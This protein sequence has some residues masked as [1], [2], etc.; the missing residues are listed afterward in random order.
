MADVRR[1]GTT[2]AA[3][4][5]ILALTAL[6]TLFGVDLARRA[7]DPSLVDRETYLS[8]IGLG[9]TPQEAQNLT[10]LTA[11]ILLGLCVL[12]TAMG[13]G[14]LRRRESVRH[15]AIGTFAVFA[16]ITIPLSITG[17]VADD[18]VLGAWIGLAIGATDALIVWQLLKPATTAD[19]E[20]AESARSR[21]RYARHAER[22]AR[23]KE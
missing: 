14:V 18:R 20:R 9:L 13:I 8:A 11:I 4:L 6:F 22:A 21:A 7:I 17:I 19:F 16:L 1:S 23:R 12:T 3:G 10:T 2:N 5:L 15:A